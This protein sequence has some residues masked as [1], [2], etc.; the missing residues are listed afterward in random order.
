MAEVF[1]PVYYVDPQT[2]KR[3]P[4]NFPGAVRRRSKTWHIRYYTPD[5]QRHKE[6]GYR[7]KKATETLAAERERRGIR[8]DAGLVDPSDIH[9]KKPL[10]GHLADYLK[11]LTDKGN[12]AKHVALTATR[13][14][15]CLDACRFVRIADIQPAA[16]VSF[17]ADL[18]KPSKDPDGNETTGKNVTTANYYLTAAKGFTRWLAGLGRRAT[19]DPLAGMTRLA[20]AGV[21]VRHARRDFSAEELRW[22]L[23]T[24]LASDRAFRGLAGPDRY[25]LYLTA[26]GTGLRVSELASLAPPS[27]DLDASPPV[28]RA[29]AA[30]TKNRKEAEQPLPGDVTEAL[31][32]YLE[33]RPVDALVWPGTWTEKAAA[34]LRKDLADARGKWLQTFDDPRQHAE[35]ERSDFLAYRNAAGLVTDFHA[36]RHT[37]ISRIVQGNASP[38]VAQELARHST[39]TL[40]LGRYAHTG[41]YDLAA[42]VNDLPAIVTAPGPSH[43]NVDVLRATG[44]VGQGE[45]GRDLKTGQNSLGPNLGPRPAISGDFLRQ[46]ETEAAASDTGATPKK[47][48]EKQGKPANFQGR[49]K[50]KA[51]GFEPSTYGLKVRCSTS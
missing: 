35:V 44:T 14:R 19:M 21:D 48:L 13:V 8:L 4:S 38:K 33:G 3:V 7:D 24:T 31:R 2:K 11:Y 22:L 34:M 37:Y 17:L 25:H 49:K 12:T 47:S 1:R 20:N 23:S 29:E 50:V 6:K 15:A 27:F 41:L 9:A 40:T 18:R 26:A 16:V 32:G 30:Y 10:A 39:V 5:G 28:V 51:E 45:R 43:A 42:A 36:L 46:T